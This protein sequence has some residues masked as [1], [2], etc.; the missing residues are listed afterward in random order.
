MT[1]R[2]RTAQSAHVTCSRHISQHEAIDRLYWLLAQLDPA[3]AV[4][5]GAVEPRAVTF[6]ATGEMPWR[7][8][9]GSELAAIVEDL[10]ERRASAA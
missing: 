9:E 4:P 7:L 10:R 1:T 2:H 5:W 6:V 3:H 8:A